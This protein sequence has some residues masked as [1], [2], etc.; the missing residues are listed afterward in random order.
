[1]KTPLLI[2]SVLLLIAIA[3]MPYGYY[4]FLRIAI[5][6]VAGIIAYSLFEKN[7]KKSLVAFVVIMILYNPILVIHLER[8]IWSPINIVTAVFF[9]VFAFVNKKID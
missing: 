9:I 4:Q 8:A 2:A 1:M 5:T 7:Q 3:P 6:I